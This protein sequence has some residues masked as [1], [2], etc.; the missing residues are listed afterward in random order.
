MAIFRKAQAPE[1]PL[2]VSVTGVRLGMRVLGILG[3]DA[4]PFFELARRVGLTGRAIAVAENEQLAAAIGEAAINDGVT[5]DVMSPYLP[6]TVPDESVDL[7]V[8]D[9]RVARPAPYD[10]ASLLTHVRAA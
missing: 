9:E 6:L 7:V 1:T 2:I 3:Q 5:L 10:L 4:R 8:V